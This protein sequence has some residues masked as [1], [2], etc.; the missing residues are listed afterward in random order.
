MKKGSKKLLLILFF[1]L[2]TTYV[3]LN[4]KTKSTVFPI[5]NI[6]IENND[7][8]K[9]E[10]VLEEL[11]FLF[12]ED[13]M[14]ISDLKIKKA[15]DNI[16]FVLSAKIKKIYPNTLKIIIEEKKPIAIM[17]NKKKKFYIT[18][19]GNLL[20]FDN[21]RKFANLPLVFGGDKNFLILISALKEINF[22]TKDIKNFYYFEIGR[23]DIEFKNGKILKLPTDNFKQSL[24]NFN[25][26]YNNSKFKDYMIFDYR[27]DN[28]LILK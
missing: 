15:F 24:V 5:K 18:K 19:K 7:V 27:I 16:P 17:I 23:W 25:K 3:P 8:I 14:F 2:S 21:N 9:K 26:I 12:E 11:S 10:R 6:L 22:N 20:K 1:F 13:L 4:K 28:Q